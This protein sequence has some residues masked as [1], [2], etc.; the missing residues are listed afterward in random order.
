ME[1]DQTLLI[2]IKG[3]A[4]ELQKLKTQIASFRESQSPGKYQALKKQHRAIQEKIKHRLSKM[5]KKAHREINTVIY[6]STFMGKERHFQHVLPLTEEEIRY[7][8]AI[9]NLASPVEVEILE[10]KPFITS[11]IEIKYNGHQKKEKKKTTTE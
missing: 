11:P 1:I 9:G 5:H 3:L 7:Y 10:I 8:F 4:E 6:R 2:Y